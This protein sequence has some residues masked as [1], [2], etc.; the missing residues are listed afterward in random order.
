MSLQQLYNGVANIDKTTDI[1][2]KIELKFDARTMMD[3]SKN[4]KF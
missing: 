1:R 3:E 2:D 4:A